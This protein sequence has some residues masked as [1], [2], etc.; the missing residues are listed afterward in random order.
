M[1]PAGRERFADV[2]VPVDHD[3][4][5]DAILRALVETEGRCKSDPAVRAKYIKQFKK[6]DRA[7]AVKA[8]PDLALAAGVV[9]VLVQR[10]EGEPRSV[11]VHD[12]PDR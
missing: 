7:A 4:T 6:K 1:T 5:I 3:L 11:R 12:P 10:K 8:N 2:R 9:H